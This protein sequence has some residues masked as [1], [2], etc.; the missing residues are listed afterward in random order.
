MND[1]G[2]ERD[3]RPASRLQGQ[4]RPV[5]FRSVL[6]RVGWTALVI[7]LAVL[8][9]RSG[10]LAA[11]FGLAVLISYII[12]PLV[13]A[14]ERRGAP[15]V[16]AIFTAYVIVVLALGFALAFVLPPL[17][18][19]LEGIVTAYLHGQPEV[20]FDGLADG[21]LTGLGIARDGAGAE[22][23]ALLVDRIERYIGSLARQAVEALSAVAG[24]IGNLLLAPVIAFYLT[25]D[26]HCIRESFA[27]WLP[28]G[29]REAIM[30]T[31]SAID[32]ALAGWVR[33]IAIVSAFVLLASGAV[34]T[35]LK[36]PYALPLAFIAG[37]LE[38][39]PYFGPFLGMLPAVLMASRVSTTRAVLTVFAFGA[40]QQV[41]SA[42]L[43][44]KIVGDR[45]GLH[46]LAVIS[47]LIIGGK[48]FGV[49]GLLIAVPAAAV[50]FIIARSLLAP[51]A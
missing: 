34:L 10:W 28:A 7:V 46:P 38:A 23:A 1:A 2:S 48:L 37:M 47:S 36:V 19:G 45:V 20:G 35:L 26:V 16:A 51:D 49:V 33:G 4:G 17:V 24:Q 31:V 41:E 42:V 18:K 8:L 32:S 13:E 50:L 6:A 5:S 15:R 25:R 11:P 12:S 29:C 43:S 44:P 14:A 3:H 27:S 39:V 30:A 40:I 22:I 21:W 9:A